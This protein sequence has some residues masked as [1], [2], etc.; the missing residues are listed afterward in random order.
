[1]VEAAAE[2]LNAQQRA[3]IA[4]LLKIYNTVAGFA[5]QMNS[6]GSAGGAGGE[7]DEL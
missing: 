3:E 2:S 5:E 6:A 4:K 7:R 1:M